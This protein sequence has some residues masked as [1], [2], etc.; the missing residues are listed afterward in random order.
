MLEICALVLLL[1]VSFVGTVRYTEL[2]ETE[3][4]FFHR[5]LPL[6][7][8]RLPH[9]GFD[10]AHGPPAT[11]LYQVKLP[12]LCTVMLLNVTKFWSKNNCARRFLPKSLAKSYAR[13]CINCLAVNKKPALRTQIHWIRIRI[14]CIQIETQPRFLIPN[15]G[16]LSQFIYL[17]FLYKKC[18]KFIL[19]RPP[20]KTSKLQ[21]KP[22]DL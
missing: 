8:D 16:K 20:W 5:K 21:E 17:F 1:T 4:W 3:Y 13:L 18:N 9:T 2:Y 7:C 6:P 11:H 14:Q 12:L 19:F 15:T 22:F 10:C